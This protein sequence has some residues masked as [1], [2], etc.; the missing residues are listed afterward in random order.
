M[1]TPL[2]LKHRSIISGPVSPRSTI[3]R[4]YSSRP[5]SPGLARSYTSASTSTTT[6]TLHPHH[7]ISRIFLNGSPTLVSPPPPVP[8]K[9]AARLS[10]CPEVGSKRPRIT[11]EIN[12]DANPTRTRPAK[13]HRS[14]ARTRPHLQT[15]RPASVATL[16]ASEYHLNLGQYAMNDDLLGLGPSPP[17]SP[18]PTY[19]PASPSPIPQSY[20]RPSRPPLPPS[21]LTPSRTPAKAAKLLG[22]SEISTNHKPRVLGVDVHSAMRKLQEREKRKEHYRPLPTQTLVEIERFFGEVPRNPKPHGKHRLDIVHLGLT[23]RG[24]P[25]H[26]SEARYIG[27]GREARWKDVMGNTWRDAAEEQEFAWLMSDLSLPSPNPTERPRAVSS[28]STPDRSTSERKLDPANAIMPND[29]NKQRTAGGKVAIA[30]GTMGK[31]TLQSV[32]ITPEP[33]KSQLKTARERQ[34]RPHAASTSASTENPAPAK[35]TQ[36]RNGK[37]GK[38]AARAKGESFMDFDA[39]DSPDHQSTAPRAARRDEKHVGWTSSTESLA[40]LTPPLSESSSPP[41]SP[42]AEMSPPRSPSPPRVKNR[43]P[44]LTL[45]QGRKN[46]NLPIISTTPTPRKTRSSVSGRHSESIGSSPVTP[47]VRPRRAPLPNAIELPTVPAV[48]SIGAAAHLGALPRYASIDLE[49]DTDGEI[50]L[51]AIVGAGSRY[52]RPGVLTTTTKPRV[53]QSKAARLMGL[54]PLE[55]PT[56]HDVSFFEPDSPTEARSSLARKYG[57]SAR[58]WA[59]GGGRWFKNM[60]KSSGVKV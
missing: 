52:P 43:P 53:I 30:H 39:L 44:P 45:K 7:S 19:L 47:F 51:G 4:M 46:P 3:S 38:K 2:A 21:P 12:K 35:K 60:V 22:T 40:V 27:E 54:D 55:D 20:R 5:S 13:P 58:A 31:D 15:S 56:M 18:S 50:D 9:N 49:S 11:G 57:L 32:V 25:G 48:P 24:L 26:P 41:P 28:P 29:I 59:A 42:R 37:R 17:V 8:P 10:S 16:A 34:N 33:T 1:L 14:E 23:A 6:S 36:D